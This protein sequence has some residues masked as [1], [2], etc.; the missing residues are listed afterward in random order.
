MRRRPIDDP[1]V[2]GYL[3]RADEIAAEAHAVAAAYRAR[4]LNSDPRHR[5]TRIWLRSALRVFGG[6]LRRSVPLL[7]ASTG[8]HEVMGTKR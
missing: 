1:R 5:R 6:R 4:L 7:R 3:R 2:E 8:T